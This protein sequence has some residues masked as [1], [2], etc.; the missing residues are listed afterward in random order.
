MTKH[1]QELTKQNLKFANTDKKKFNKSV[2]IGSVFATLIAITP[3]IFYT[4]E[5]VPESEIWETWL[6]TYK[7]GFYGDA[8]VGIWSILM[9]AVPVLLLF[10]W[11]F[12]CR[13]W[14]Y[15]T[16]LVPI[17][18]FTYQIIG[19]LNDDM[20]YIDE[21]QLIHLIPVMVIVIPSIYLMRARLFNTVN[22]ISK[23]TQEL[24]DELTFRPK[25]IWGKVKQFF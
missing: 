8:Q 7:S 22:T 23:S 2:I 16:L 18:M 3:F 21:F 6:F 15:H 17:A 25:T 20:E 12:T 5:Y 13:H 10:I 11:F 24:E 14:W 19:A 9:K 1:T 4:Y